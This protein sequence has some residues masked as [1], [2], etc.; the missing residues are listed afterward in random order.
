MVQAWV[1]EACQGL[2]RV[3]SRPLIL[4]HAYCLCACREASPF[5]VKSHGHPLH[6]FKLQLAESSAA[7]GSA[8]T[9]S[10][11]TAR[12]SLGRCGP[13]GELPSLGFTSIRKRNGSF[14]PAS[15][16]CPKAPSREFRA[17]TPPHVTRNDDE[18]PLVAPATVWTVPDSAS[19]S[20]GAAIEISPMRRTT[21]L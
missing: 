20:N 4:P 2:I 10:V 11:I 6:L 15:I 16:A 8:R 9:T 3:F 1:F 18:L 5:S 12:R 21:G 7:L 19:L 14:N 17:Q 13:V